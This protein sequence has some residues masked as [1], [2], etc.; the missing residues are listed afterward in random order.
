[1]NK[2]PS[3]ASQF[4][5]QLKAKASKEEALHLVVLPSAILAPAV[6]SEL[7]GSEVAW[8][9]QNCY[10]ENKGAFTGET[11]PQVLQN[12]G[13]KYCLVG[14]SERRQIFLEGDDMLAKKMKALQSLKITPILCVGETLDD[15][16][17]NRTQEVVLRQLK[18]CLL[19][20]D[21]KAPF[22]IAYEPVWAIGTGQVATVDQV[23]EVHNL[24]R[25]YLVECMG[26]IGEMTPILYGGSVKADNAGS[27]SKIENVDGFLIGG[28]S[29]VVEDF[30]AIYRNSKP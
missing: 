1:M 15:R 17:W 19:E 21:L 8:G 13:A 24:I 26:S 6:S 30:L 10:F 5:E 3:E 2:L 22:W 16:K 27:L 29:L 12:L 9:G 23:D 4:C 11:S 25:K 18:Q 20:T 28:A 7:K 14:H